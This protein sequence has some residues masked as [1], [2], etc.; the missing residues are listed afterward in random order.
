[1][2]VELAEPAA[3]GTIGAPHRLDLVA[4]EE[5]RQLAAVLG[6]DARERD[7]EVVAER[8]IGLAGGLPF[9]AAQHLVYELVALFAVLAGQ[10]LDVLECRRLERFEAVALVDA[11]HDVDHIL[12]PPHVAGQEVAHPAR[13]LGVLR[14]YCEL[15]DLTVGYLIPS[16]SR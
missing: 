3:R 12:T 1:A 13:R 7:R 10:R 4:L 11:A 16:C 9:A 6:D 5:S 15:P 2:L 14:H 8:E